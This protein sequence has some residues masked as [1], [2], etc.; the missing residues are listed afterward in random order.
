ML[1]KQQIL[2][3]S[4]FTLISLNFIGQVNPATARRDWFVGHYI[5]TLK[6]SVPNIVI[7]C[8][9]NVKKM[10]DYNINND[11]TIYVPIGDLQAVV[12]LDSTLGA[13]RFCS[14][15]LNYYSYGRLESDSSVLFICYSTGG[16]ACTYSTGGF[17]QPGRTMIF[18][19]KKVSDTPLGI[20]ES[21]LES[22][23]IALYPNPV[24]TTNFNVLTLVEPDEFIL[25]DI[26][27]KSYSI[28][29]NKTDNGYKIQ[30]PNRISSG[31]YFLNMHKGKN[32]IA[33]KIV[34]TMEN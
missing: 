15:W 12:C 26:M 33:K 24:T 28:A 32:I 25:H 1:R 18:R 21:N 8:A 23:N 13:D 2:L 30:L 19:G 17:C 6:D 16:C 7:N 31:V 10:S 4:V 34:I 9:M 3:I 5:G 20:N 27:G 14:N 11:S 22:N 29:F